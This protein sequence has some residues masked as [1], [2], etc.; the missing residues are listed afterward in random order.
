MPHVMDTILENRALHIAWMTVSPKEAKT[1]RNQWP[2]PPTPVVYFKVN[3]PKYDN[4]LISAVKAAWAGG[5]LPAAQPWVE[6]ILRIAEA[7]LVSQPSLSAG[8]RA[9]LALLDKLACFQFAAGP[10][11]GFAASAEKV[12]SRHT[13][14][15]DESLRS[16]CARI[17]AAMGDWESLADLMLPNAGNE[18][19]PEDLL[20]QIGFLLPDAFLLAHRQEF[21]RNTGMAHIMLGILAARGTVCGGQSLREAALAR[22]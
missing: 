4:D 21:A 6:S 20:H 22:N 16:S 2:A 18:D 5:G 9:A 10:L 12:L 13:P 11:P 3:D 15:Y 1:A 19:F 8:P 7:S 17:R 14:S